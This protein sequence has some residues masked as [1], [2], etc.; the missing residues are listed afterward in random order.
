MDFT[1][2]KDYIF[3]LKLAKL[4][5]LN[6]ILNSNKT[7]LFG[8]IVYYISIMLIGLYLLTVALW[9][10]ISLF[11][12][13]NDGTVFTYYTGFIINL[14]MTCCKVVT[15]LYYFK[16][17]RECLKLTNCNFLSYLYYDKNVFANWRR[18]SIRLLYIFN[19]VSL[20]AL[21]IWASSPLVLK[22]TVFTIRLVDGSISR[23]R[24]NVY[25]CFSMI[26]DDVY[27]NNFN[28]FLVLEIIL[29]SGYQ[30]ITLLFD[31][32]VIIMSNVFSSQLETINNGIASLNHEYPQHN[33]STYYI[34]NINYLILFVDTL[35]YYLYIYISLI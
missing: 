10:L 32:F 7:N 29:G 13:I 3:D 18:R 5:G 28:K 27:N 24:M 4:S 21:I 34:G 25:N 8:L 22:G 33:P 31:N 15:V 19:I 16:D 23:Q 12:I 17:I 20:M 35:S 9:N 2:E 6:N 11:K 26:S 1:N 14:L 30:Y